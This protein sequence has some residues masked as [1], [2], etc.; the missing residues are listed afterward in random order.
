MWG[1]AYRLLYALRSPIRNSRP[2]SSGLIAIYRSKSEWTGN[3]TRCNFETPRN[4]SPKSHARRFG[5]AG[6]KYSGGKDNP[7]KKKKPIES[8]ERRSDVKENKTT[9]MHPQ[10]PSLLAHSCHH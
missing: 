8:I 2:D 5:K 9:K 1:E 10:D 7:L 4:T 3:K 6:K